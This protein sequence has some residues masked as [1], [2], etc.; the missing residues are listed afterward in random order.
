MHRN[1]TPRVVLVLALLALGSCADRTAEAHPPAAAGAAASV[2]A[3]TAGERR[4]EATGSADRFQVTLAATRFAG[5]HQGTGD[6]KC[7]MYN[8]LWQASYEAQVQTGISA[9]MVQL[10]EIPAAG[11]STDKLTFSV[12][13]GQ[14]DDMSG[15]AGMVDLAGSEYG[16]DARATVTREGQGAVLRIEGTAQQNGRVTAELRCASVEMMR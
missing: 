14:M 2:D 9:L 13:F 6:L 1:H 3:G 16:G 4:T 5:T 7:M 8:G 11:G 10:K 12:V 15:N